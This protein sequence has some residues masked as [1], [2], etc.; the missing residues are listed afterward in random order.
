MP[1]SARPSGHSVQRHRRSTPINER[2]ELHR[3]LTRTDANFRPLIKSFSALATH[4]VLRRRLASRGAARERA[5][6]RARSKLCA[7]ARRA[8]LKAEH[9]E[10]RRHVSTR[11]RVGGVHAVLGQAL[12]NGNDAG[13]RTQHKVTGR[14]FHQTIL[15]AHR[16]GGARRTETRRKQPLHI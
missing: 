1:P 12:T 5:T 11:R 14:G 15:R 4:R 3:D 6:E 7:I 13:F 2:I 8:V 9:H 10:L 16:A